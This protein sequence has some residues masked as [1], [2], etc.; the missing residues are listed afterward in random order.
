MFDRLECTASRQR[1][2][3]DTR[4]RAEQENSLAASTMPKYP[5][6]DAD[7]PR[8]LTNSCE[9][10]LIQNSSV[11]RHLSLEGRTRLPRIGRT[12]LRRRRTKA[13][14]IADIWQ[15]RRPPDHI[16]ARPSESSSSQLSRSP[17]PLDLAIL[18]SVQL[19]GGPAGRLHLSRQGPK[20][21]A[22]AAT[23]AATREKALPTGGMPEPVLGRR[24]RTAWKSGH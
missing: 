8:R 5:L 16:R 7:E 6:S 9:T 19:L 13:L 23:I 24:L 2:T 11:T 22:R 10:P 14:W 17:F 12:L 15:G 21:S 20:G 3:T 1:T 18:G 4:V